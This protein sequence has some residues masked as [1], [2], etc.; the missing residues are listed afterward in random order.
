MET[1]AAVATRVGPGASHLPQ[2][3]LAQFKGESLL[4]DRLGLLG[5]LNV[6]QAPGRRLLGFGRAQ[7]EQ[8]L[9][10]RERHLPQLFEALDQALELAPAHGTFLADP[11]L[12]LVAAMCSTCSSV[13]SSAAPNKP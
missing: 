10:A 4:V 12:A 6:N 9:I 7:L 8:E 5:D 13:S 3:V 11:V 2:L 1:G